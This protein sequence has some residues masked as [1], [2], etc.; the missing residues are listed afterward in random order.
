MDLNIALTK[1]ERDARKELNRKGSGQERMWALSNHQHVLQLIQGFK[2]APESYKDR[3][4]RLAESF[5]YKVN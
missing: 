1:V 5:G 3:A 2:S 4:V